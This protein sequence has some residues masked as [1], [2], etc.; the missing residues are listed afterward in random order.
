MPPWGSLKETERINV[1]SYIK[2]F[3][4]RFEINLP[5]EGTI[6]YPSPPKTPELILEGKL[7]YQKTGCDRCHGSTGKGDGTSANNLRDDW[8]N[9]I[10]PTD[11]YQ[12]II[13]TGPEDWK[14]YRTIANGL[15]GTP[16]P[17]SIDQLEPNEIWA[18]VYYIRSLKH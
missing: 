5:P 8:D 7:I 16:M 18:L 2:T 9:L 11:F 12:G 15:G 17:S 13:K 14:I 4:N 1:I 6:I 10:S 3:S